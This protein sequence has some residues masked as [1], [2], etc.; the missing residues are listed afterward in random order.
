ME[1]RPPDFFLG[2]SEHRGDWARARAC[3]LTRRLRMADGRECVLVEIDP[4]VIGQPFGLGDQDISDLVLVPRQRG[5]AF[6]PLGDHPVAVLAYRILSPGGLA[7]GVVQDSDVEL[8]AW[9]ELY[10][11]L[12]AAEQAARDP[13]WPSPPR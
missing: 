10:T 1:D 7:G 2:S 12:E 9:C 6:A 4:P 8:I 3:R 13:G 5:G 11:S